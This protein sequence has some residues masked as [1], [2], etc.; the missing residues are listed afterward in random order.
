MWLKVSECWWE[1]WVVG[2]D[3]KDNWIRDIKVIISG[4]VGWLDDIC[5]AAGGL[6]H[7]CRRRR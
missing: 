5:K 1:M 3:P 2:T 4:V 7:L 6:G